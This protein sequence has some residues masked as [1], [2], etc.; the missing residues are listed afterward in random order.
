VVDGFLFHFLFAVPLSAVVVAFIAAHVVDSRSVVIGHS[1]PCPAFRTETNR[2]ESQINFF[3]FLKKK[4]Q[5][6]KNM[7]ERERGGI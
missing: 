6:V 7:E 3:F 4:K 5:K 2:K 1:A